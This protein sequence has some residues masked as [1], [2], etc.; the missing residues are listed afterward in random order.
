MKTLVLSLYPFYS[1]ENKT[2]C[3]LLHRTTLQTY[4]KI[5][6][7]VNIYTDSTGHTPGCQTFRIEKML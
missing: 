1:W 6:L 4:Q 5:E 2:E 3:Q 7:G